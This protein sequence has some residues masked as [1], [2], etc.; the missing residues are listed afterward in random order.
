MRE[1]IREAILARLM[2]PRRATTEPGR[3]TTRISSL[4]DRPVATGKPERLS[5]IE[6]DFDYFHSNS[7]FF[8]D[9]NTLPVL[10]LPFG[11]GQQ[12]TT[13]YLATVRP[14]IGIA[15]DRNFGYITGGVAFTKANYTESYADAN[16]PPATGAAAG[17]R[18]LTGWTAGA[19]W[20]YAW[21]DHW[22]LRVEYLYASFSTTSALGT[23]TEPGTGTN[24]L[25]GSSDLVIQV[26]R[27]AANF[28]F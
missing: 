11:I 6:G 20:E 19:G 27:A 3:T 13:N 16:T 25:H 4:A 28:K 10:G 23:I 24:V 22:L 26:I 5:G 15:A 14:R 21:T 2:R 12:L 8:N 9:T 1:S 18:S 7:S 17:S